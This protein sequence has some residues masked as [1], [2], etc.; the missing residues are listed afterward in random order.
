M[1]KQR[2][3]TQKYVFK[4]GQKIVH[5]GITKR[6]LEER[7]AEHQQKW[8]KGHI[9]KVG[10]TTTEEAARDWEKEKGYS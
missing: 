4:D 1:A 6:P 7:E 10:R 9:V 3:D 8:P 5:G 2:R